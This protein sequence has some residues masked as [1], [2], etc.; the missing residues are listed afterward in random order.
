M[1]GKLRQAWTDYWFEPAPLVNL[2]VCRIVVAGF[3]LLWLATRT[4]YARLAQEASYPDF[5]YDPLPVLHLLVWPVGW[6]YR[7]GLEVLEAAFTVALI[8]GALAVIGLFT[9]ASLALFTLASVFLHAYAYS[10]GDFHHPEGVIVISLA[11]L[12]LA[13]SGEVLSLDRRL[14]R[15]FGGD[16]GTGSAADGREL[17]SATSEYARWPLRVIA[18]LMALVYLSAAASKIH[19]AGLE[20]MNGTTLQYY[21]IQDGL[22]WDSALGIWFGEQ[23]GLS[24]ALS[25]LTVLFEGTFVLVLVAPALA[26]IYVP[27]GAALHLGIYVTMKAPFFGWVALYCVFVP[28]RDVGR[29]LRERLARGPSS[30]RG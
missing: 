20:W 29:W 23:H 22:R 12:T 2:A 25:W 19:P 13:P 3:Q 18:W 11:L 8:S 16:G 7:P 14:G 9:R 28:W 5:L 26:L 10:F 6:T 1:I 15:W 21:L 30:V 27:L 17:L 4:D 24:T